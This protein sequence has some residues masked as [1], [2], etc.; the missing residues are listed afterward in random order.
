M[1]NFAPIPLHEEIEKILKDK[2]GL[3][4]SFD[5]IRGFLLNNF[6]ESQSLLL[7]ISVPVD[8][9]PEISLK[10]IKL[11][12]DPTNFVISLK[13]IS[14]NVYVSIDDGF[15]ADIV[16]HDSANP[17]NEFSTITLSVTKLKARLHVIEPNLMLSKPDF[18]VLGSIVEANHRAQAILDSRIPETSIFRVEGSVES[19]TPQRFVL[20]LFGSISK[21]D[22]L[23]MFSA[24][25]LKGSWET[26]M[27]SNALAIVPSQGI[28]IKSQNGC[29]EKDSLP[30]LEIGAEIIVKESQ[31]GAYSWL[32]ATVSGVPSLKIE[33]GNDTTEGFAS[34]YLPK[35][36]LEQRFGN[37]MPSLGYQESVES[38]IGYDLN[39]NVA[40]EYISLALDPAR[41][42]LIIDLEFYTSGFA[43][44]NIDVPCV[45][46]SDLANARFKGD[47]SILQ[48]FISL[49]NYDGSRLSFQAQV[50]SL[51]LGKINATIFAISKWAGLAGGKGAVI[52]FIADYVLKRVAEHILPIKMKKGIKDVVNGFNFPLLELESLLS[53][54]R[55]KKFNETN[56]SASKDSLLLGL[57]SRG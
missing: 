39:L 35:P 40:F 41:M 26:M 47:K 23:K 43:D 46:R 18:N 1:P 50:E 25:E 54:S 32:G 15:T 55:Y 48:I 10:F 16:V 38:F 22:L 37:V 7:G 2:P 51:N 12:V 29:P 11:S 30:K 4:F 44:A 42:G 53:Y 20:P 52:G 57:N 28:S 31:Q 45:G 33:R 17:A 36:V 9:T 21:L 8:G 3:I 34:I 24:F 6:K 14:G 5:A 19:V 56:Y 13:E 27:I 49:A